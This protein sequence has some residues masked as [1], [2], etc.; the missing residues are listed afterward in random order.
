MKRFVATVV[1]LKLVLVVGFF[2]LFVYSQSGNQNAPVVQP[3][4]PVFESTSNKIDRPVSDPYTG[5][6]SIFENVDR[7]KNLQIDRVMDILKISEKKSVADIGAGSGWFTVKAARRTVTGPVFA[8]E[9]NQDYLDYIKKRAKTESLPNITTILGKPNDPMLTANS[10]DAVMLLKT[11][12]EI[13][14]P[15]SLMKNVRC[16]LKPGGLVGII[17]KNG[18]GDDHGLNQDKV[19]TEMKLAGFSLKDQYDFVK[20]DGMDYFLVFEVIK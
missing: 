6:L 10:V 19:V 15:I 9:I 12:H 1:A 5:D 14:E 13:A 18:S 11:Y 20:P 7:A 8:V 17:D 16:S 3:T 2:T 4:P